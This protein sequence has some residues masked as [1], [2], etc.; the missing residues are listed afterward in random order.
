M[1]TYAALSLICLP[2]SFVTLGFVILGLKTLFGRKL[3]INFEL[4]TVVWAGGEAVGR[5]VSCTHRGTWFESAVAVAVETSVRSR[6][7]TTL[8]AWKNKA[9]A[10]AQAAVVRTAPEV[11]VTSPPRAL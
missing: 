8:A 2:F 5:A 3:Q 11:L 6:A 9:L 4:C 7:K 10:S 1:L